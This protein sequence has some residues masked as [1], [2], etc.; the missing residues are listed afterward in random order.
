MAVVVDTSALYAY[1]D[2]SARRHAD[3]QALVDAERSP[4]MITSGVLIELDALLR[5]RV[6]THTARRVSDE[7]TSGA[8]EL[9]E[10]SRDDLRRALTIMDRWRDRELS[11]TDASLL[12]IADRKGASTIFTLD[13]RGF[14]G[15]VRTD[16]TPL[17][18]LP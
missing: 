18:I 2:S 4:L 5:R 8:Y 13:R 16:G 6:N 12:E 15:L 10:C 1:F 14:G 17:A 11:L 3:L 7:L 9:I